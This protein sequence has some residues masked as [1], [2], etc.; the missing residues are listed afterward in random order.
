MRWFADRL[1]R[2][3]EELYH[4]K[5]YDFKK[6]H[7]KTP[8]IGWMLDFIQETTEKEEHITKERKPQEHS[9]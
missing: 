1:P 4:A 7:R 3:I 2:N 5:L 6:T 8:I 9:W